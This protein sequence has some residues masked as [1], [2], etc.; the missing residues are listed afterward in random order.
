MESAGMNR[1]G[2]LSIIKKEIHG[3]KLAFVSLNDVDMKIDISKVEQEFKK[4][5]KDD[6]LIT[7]N[8]HW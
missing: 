1:S 6:Y 8:V 5:K 7:V 3:L 4:L 2:D